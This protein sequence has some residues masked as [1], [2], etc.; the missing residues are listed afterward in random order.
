[1]SSTF[2]DVPASLSSLSFSR[3][4]SS[5]LDSPLAII[6]SNAIMPAP[7]ERLNDIGRILYLD[8][9]DSFTRNV[10]DLVESTLNVLVTVW[11][12][13][14]EWPEN[15]QDVIDAYDA[16]I[17]GP[18]PGTPTNPDDV[19]SMDHLWELDN[20][21]VLGVC[22]GFQ[23]L[24]V[25]YGAT[26]RK[27]PTPRH[28]KVVRFTHSGKDIFRNLPESFDVTLYH[29]LQV[30]L[31][32]PIESSGD[33]SDRLLCWSPSR[34]SDLV[35]LAWYQD[36]AS[37]KANLMAVR[38]QTKP[39]WGV[40]FHPESCKS[41]T[42]CRNMV[43]NWWE[44]V[45][46]HNSKARTVRRGPILASGPIPK[47]DGYSQV[48]DKMIE[49]CNASSNVA[50]YQTLDRGALTT[51]RIC[52]LVDVP[53]VPS[54]VLDSTSRYS[55]IS[56]LSSGAW[57]LEYS[58]STK[59]GNMSRLSNQDQSVDFA[60]EPGGIWELL[61]LVLSKKKV[62]AGNST[63]PFW[64]G[65][66]GYF[67]YEM[68]LAGLCEQ[69]PPE[70]MDGE[71]TADVGL[72]WV[73]R[74]IVIDREDSK[75]HIQSIR[76]SDHQPGDWID[77]TTRHLT[78]IASR[79]SK[80]RVVPN[81]SVT[82][83]QHLDEP[84]LD[85]ADKT[86]AK[87]MIKKAEIIMP[88]EVVYKTKI[89]ECHEYIGDGESYELCLTDQA[90][91]ILPQ[92][93]PIQGT[94]VRP[95]ILYK[96]LR[97]YTPAA[98]GAYAT[99][100]KAK[101]ISSSPECFLEYDRKG[102][103]DMK[104]MKGTVKKGEGMTLEKAK[105]ILDTP[106]EMGEN[107]MIADLVRHDMFN[108]CK[109]GG[110]TVHKLLE[111]EEHARVY[112]LITHIRG[113]PQTL[114]PALQGWCPTH[115]REKATPHDYSALQRCLPP[116]SMTGAPKKRSCELLQ[117][118]EGKKRSIYSGVMGYLDA[119]GGAAFSVLI[120]TAYSWSKVTD[121]KEIWRVG[122]GGAVTALSTPQG[123]WDEMVTKLETVLGVFRS[124]SSDGCGCASASA[125]TGRTKKQAHHDK[126]ESVIGF[127][128]SKECICMLS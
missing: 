4:S 58:L 12:I 106:K 83:Y 111:V 75:I 29:S 13:D 116:G 46:D 107:L 113:I 68:G 2:E 82:G 121:E 128:K 36:V 50:S 5:S 95:W 53:C 104:P 122:A 70:T 48:A 26:I 109:S 99:I 120:R 57:T 124:S 115:L 14:K 51:E 39:L 112:Q 7:E 117:K 67:S 59:Q 92:S 38:H 32:H 76:R 123:E 60:Q 114:P 16:I 35:P 25:K 62:V 69:Q 73:E 105:Q 23:S 90:Q 126:V 94:D 10:V 100:G 17:A 47:G 31:G 93:Q 85:F 9:Y 80:D 119:S 1:M 72:I 40:Q 27:L 101:I 66:M 45:V 78:E 88:D 3:S 33:L 84:M 49:W 108:V 54:V 43:K 19:G 96:R 81:I 102:Q 79:G 64:G 125:S 41:D 28:G 87:M 86:H 71:E 118:I 91:V 52:E 61:R 37:G 65:F 24:C 63:I 98:Y 110:V 97:K 89:A 6:Q 20:I 21:P 30:H 42:A 77:L 127:G 18:G 11:P 34:R 15:K 55:I 74:S 44:S 22:L 8:A 103:F 56:V